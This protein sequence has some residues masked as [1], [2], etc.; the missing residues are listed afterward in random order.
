MRLNGGASLAAI[1]G[2]ARQHGVAAK[3]LHDLVVERGLPVL[4]DAPRTG[5]VA[6]VARP[7][8]GEVAEVAPAPAPAVQPSPT[9]RKPPPSDCS[10]E[11]IARMLD[12]L[13]RAREAERRALVGLAIREARLV[14]LG[15]PPTDEAEWRHLLDRGPAR[16]AK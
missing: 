15:H 1:R 10:G 8:T 2:Y 13:E 5:E 12:D 9:C 7:G 3:V 4:P 16:S 6:E 14:F 11:Q